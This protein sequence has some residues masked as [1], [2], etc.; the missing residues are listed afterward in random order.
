MVIYSDSIRL[1]KN[2]SFFA[3]MGEKITQERRNIAGTSVS[4][5]IS[6]GIEP[7][8]CSLDDGIPEEL[9]G[10][11]VSK[12]RAEAIKSPG[13]AVTPQ[14]PY[15]IFKTIEQYENEN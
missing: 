9:G 3:F 4:Y 5:G 10:Y 13:N 1:Q 12:W 11:A 14:I 6:W 15:Q 2:E 7:E 8:I